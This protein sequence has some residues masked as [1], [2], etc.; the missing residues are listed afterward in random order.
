[1]SD[2]IFMNFAGKRITIFGCGYLGERVARHL[3]GL[4][5][6]V[7]ALTRNE[8]QAKYLSRLGVPHVVVAD[9][10]GDAWHSQ[11]NARQDHV[12]NCVS[13]AGGGWDGYRTSYYD[14][15]RSVLAWAQGGSVANLV[16]TSSTS[17]YA[18]KEGEWI[19]EASDA[20]GSTDGGK[21]LIETEHLL[22]HAGGK[23][24]RTFS[25]RLGG[26]YGPGRHYL[27]ERALHQTQH[28]QEGDGIFLNSIRVEDA[29]A[30]VLAAL[31]AP[32]EVEGGV[33]N[34]VD[35]HPAPKGE[36]VRWLHGEA[37]ARGMLR[38]G[39]AASTT[40]RRRPA[41]GANRR[42]SNEKAKRLL[43]WSPHYSCYRFGYGELLRSGAA[44]AP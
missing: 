39:E 7:T 3:L 11:I 33:F 43:G 31:A 23:G 5:S 41:G 2:H 14:G 26:I 25:L 28:E 9:L 8:E 13:S 24:M 10:H 32:P 17:V 4:G 42:I 15:M 40:S 19:T 1:M 21:I 12:V 30:A 22:F 44:S 16:F 37:A 18:Q 36:I 34:I 35:D 27:L 38:E 20:T 29:A 6:E